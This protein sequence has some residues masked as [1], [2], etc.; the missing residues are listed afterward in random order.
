MPFW[1]INGGLDRHSEDDINSTLN[2]YLTL[3]DRLKR[4][5]ST[6]EG[7]IKDEVM[8]YSKDLTGTGLGGSNN[9]DGELA[10]TP[11]FESNVFRNL[12]M[13]KSTLLFCDSSR[14]DSLEKSPDVVMIPEGGSIPM[15]KLDDNE[16]NQNLEEDDLDRLNSSFIENLLNE[17]ENLVTELVQ[18]ENSNLLDFMC[19]GFFIK[20]LNDKANKMHYEKVLNL[21][22][23]IDKLLEEID[24]IE[25]YPAYS[26]CS[27]EQKKSLSHVNTI[28]SILSLNSTLLVD[29]IFTNNGKHKTLQ[30]LWS[31]IKSKHLKNEE[32]S[33]SNIFLKIHNN[34]LSINKDDYIKFLMN[35]TQLVDDFLS[36]IDSSVLMDFLL[37]CIATDSKDNSNGFLSLLESQNLMTKLLDIVEDPTYP[38]CCKSS[39]SDVLKA[40]IAISANSQ[41]HEMTIGP[42]IL[43]RKLASPSMVNRVLAIIVEKKGYSLNIIIGVIIE[44]IRKNNH[45]FD[46]INILNETL[47]SSPPSDRDPIYLGYLLTIFAENLQ[48]IYQILIDVENDDTIPLLE[49]Q[50]GQKFKPLGFERLKIVE[51][52]AELLHCSNMGILNSKNSMQ[53]AIERDQYRLNKD[54][55]KINDKVSIE[56][57]EESYDTPYISEESN[58]KLRTDPSP[59]DLFKI[60][61]Y[62]LGI[63]SKLLNLF[64]EYQF[65]SF[66]DNVVYDIIQQI[67]N[68][69]MD[70]TYNAFLVYDL[71]DSKLAMKYRDTN[72][73]ELMEKGFKQVDDFDIINNFILKGYKNSYDFYEKM[74]TNLGYM[75]HLVLIAEEIVKF[76]NTFD[77]KLI[78]PDIYEKLQDHDW[79]HYSN[80]VLAETRVMYSKILSG[81]T[82]VEDESGN[83]TP[84]I[85]DDNNPSESNNDTDMLE[86]DNEPLDHIASPD[87]KVI[88]LA[89]DRT[90]KKRV[91]NINDLEDKLDYSTE[92]DLHEKLREILIERSQREVDE[93]NK[94]NG[95]IVLGP[96]G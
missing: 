1:P 10:F 83:I 26:D 11:E 79:L 23:L 86:N 42:N 69:R 67:C 20:P 35:N 72:V 58:A 27:E 19:L 40:I 37:Q 30:K 36:F 4:N 6:I 56:V 34:L 18:N 77:V 45:D 2:E 52:I 28:A 96:T 82:F 47:N 74:N 15:S 7:Y 68:G 14:K 94:A 48:T 53:I 70:I 24:E 71:F 93:R 66:W 91:C 16:I 81:G 31:I 60:R 89:R 85:P 29:A 64:L 87:N 55:K 49:N 95:V 38:A 92:S 41:V 51:L 39:A 22:Y 25:N 3:L 78:S 33:G 44:L 13:D 50:I 75:G 17:R 8:K 90:M 59:G 57:E 80:E 5:N 65:N 32:S 9:G 76:S 73:S 12:D 43:T 84:Q 61:L 63:L 62:D 46:H 88:N 21:E 54:G